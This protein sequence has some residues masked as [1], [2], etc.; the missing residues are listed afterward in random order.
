MT[1]R[2]TGM[3][4]AKGRL[5]TL[6]ILEHALMALTPDGFLRW[7]P[8]EVTVTLATFERTYKVLETYFR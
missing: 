3:Q 6:W 1:G 5:K 7:R 4:E 8:L 2:E